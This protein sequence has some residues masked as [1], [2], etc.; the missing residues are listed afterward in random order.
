MFLAFMMFAGFRLMKRSRH[1]SKFLLIGQ[2]ES[3][4]LE[5]KRKHHRMRDHHG[6]DPGKRDQNKH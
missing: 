5:E 3:G 1:C 2:N 4:I 6:L